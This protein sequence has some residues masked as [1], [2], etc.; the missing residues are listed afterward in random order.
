M[1]GNDK[2]ELRINGCGF[3]KTNPLVLF[4]DID[5]TMDRTHASQEPSKLEKGGKRVARAVRK[6]CGAVQMA[7]SIVFG[8]MQ[9]VPKGME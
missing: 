3:S 5:P 1:R 6:G 7:L 2:V 4:L 9:K 8:A